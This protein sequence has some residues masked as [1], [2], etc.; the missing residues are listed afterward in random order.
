[1]DSWHGFSA[2]ELG[3]GGRWGRALEGWM[4]QVPCDSGLF[5]QLRARR[6][7]WGDK[8]GA[9]LPPWCE[10][11]PGMRPRAP[12][13]SLGGWQA[14]E[15]A[16]T[17]VPSIPHLQGSHP[18]VPIS[19]VGGLNHHC[20]HIEATDLPVQGQPDPEK[21]PVLCC[22]TQS[23]TWLFTF[24]HFSYIKLKVRGLSP[25]GERSGASVT[26]ERGPQSL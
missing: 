7:S 4:C 15:G 2:C 12:H 6:L 24:L 10:G 1:M 26:I 18:Q 20:R 9:P 14:T 17:P 13:Q 11:V 25:L 16:E 19:S 21:H 22:G 3:M 8:D 23:H 5:P